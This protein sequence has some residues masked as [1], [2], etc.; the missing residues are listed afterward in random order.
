VVLADRE[1]L[2]AELVGERR[3]L[4]DLA[5]A[6]IRR[7]GGAQ[8]TEGG[9][10]QLHYVRAR[11]APIALTCACSLVGAAEDMRRPNLEGRP[12]RN[13]RPP[14]PAG[15]P[16][17]AGKRLRVVPPCGQQPDRVGG[18]PV[19]DKLLAGLCRP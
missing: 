15:P 19:K 3:L 17:G 4:H 10:A 11:V 16:S 1:H 7:N 12:S 2:Q 14:K 18:R 6:L 8:V 13:P 5:Q 9:K